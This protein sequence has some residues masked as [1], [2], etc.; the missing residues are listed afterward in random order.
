MRFPTDLAH[1]IEKV[2]E[3]QELQMLHSFGEF[4]SFKL[5][6]RSVCQ[7]LGYNILSVLQ[8]F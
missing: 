4:L 6:V 7:N 3:K 2:K 5:N 8:I 1:R